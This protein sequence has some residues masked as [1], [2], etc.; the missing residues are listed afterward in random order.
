MGRPWRVGIGFGFGFGVWLGLA[1]ASGTT[2]ALADEGG[3]GAGAGGG[4]AR[5]R[6]NILWI[7]IED[8]SPDFG[9]YGDKY[10]ISPVVDNLAG[11]GIRY[12]RAFAHAGVCAPARSG[13]ITGMYPSSIGTHHMRCQGVPPAE[14]RCFPE[15]LR[16]AGYFCTNN[17]KTDYQ[18]PSPAS[19]WDENSGRA[20]W[21]SAARGSGRPFFAVFNFTQTHESQIRDPGPATTELVAT[22]GSSRRHNPALAPLPPYFPDTPAARRDVANYYNNLTAVEI[23]IKEL[24]DQLR[25][26]GLEEETIVWFWGD[27][28]RGLPRHKRWLYDSG[29]RVPLIVRIPEKWREW[30]S[31]GGELPAAGGATDELVS[32]IDF[33]PTVLSLAGAPIPGHMQGRA[34]LGPERSRTPARQ[35]VHGARD[36]MDE[37][38][39][40]IRAVR[41]GRYKYI[42]NFMPDMPYAQHVSYGELMP[43]MADWRRLAAEGGLN[44]A[45]ALF[46]SP[47][48]PLEELYDTWNDPHEVRNLARDPE[49]QDALRRLR[50]ELRRWMLEIRDAGLIHETL[51]DDWKRGG[52]DPERAEAPALTGARGVEGGTMARFGSLTPGA[53]IVHRWLDGGGGAGEGWALTP[54]ELFV[55]TGRGVRV[56]ACRAGYAD[57]EAREFAGL[58]GETPTMVLQPSLRPHWSSALGVDEGSAVNLARL[59][60]WKIGLDGMDEASGTAES[61]RTLGEEALTPMRH[62]AL[63]WLRWRCRTAERRE[64]ARGALTA[65]LDGGQPPILR[66]EAAETLLSWGNGEGE[67]SEEARRVLEELMRHPREMVRASALLAVDHLGEAGSAALPAVRALP[68]RDREYPSRI[69]EHILR[70]RGADGR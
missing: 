60:D 61:L 70:T 44:P 10:A 8:A 26:D 48:K 42:R 32:F 36:R 67:G 33:A 68:E 35:Y 41:D 4:A 16:A 1:A 40:L 23:K 54:E 22:L 34:F 64:S 62:W 66:I 43:T 45:Q 24:L 53:T 30:A 25:A 28:G 51:L 69:R 11:E 39:D 31:G 38:Y 59:L 17:V 56:M 58:T 65:H 50:G 47:T 18:F 29:I 46:M 5:G 19:A 63:R 3:A 52:D 37:R 2:A 49:H 12:D 9:C 7:S 27:H 55:P 15:Y 13:I 21:R 20:H 14:V 6:P 57:S